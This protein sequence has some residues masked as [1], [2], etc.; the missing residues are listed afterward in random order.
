MVAAKLP[1]TPPR[2]PLWIER[3]TQVKLILASSSPYRRQLLERLGLPF[4]CISPEI[5]ETPIE[6]EVPEQL[7]KRLAMEK[8]QCI[9]E[10]YPDAVVVGSDQ[11]AW[12]E[13]RQL[14]KPGNAQT[15]IQQLMACSGKTATFFTG[16]ALYQNKGI[17]QATVERYEARFRHLSRDQIE[18]YVEREQAFHCAGGFKMEGLGIALFEHLRGDDPNTLIGLP[19]IRLCAMLEEAGLQVL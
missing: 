11:V 14:H 6:G 5:D 12:L 10:Q 17:R 16:L 3:D 7:A 19:L 13:G 1:K 15:N 8:A 9:A 2:I 18:H 4:E